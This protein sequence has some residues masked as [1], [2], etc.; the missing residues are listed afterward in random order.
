MIFYL[1]ALIP[2]LIG[3]I[4]WVRSL[5]IVLW[6]WLASTAIGFALAGAFHYAAIKGMTD[7][8]ETWSGKVTDARQFSAWKEYYEYAVYRTESETYTDSDG[9]THTTYHQVFD[10]WEPTSRWHDAYWKAYSDIDYDLSI[11][12]SKYAYLTNK[13]G[14]QD[15]VKGDRTTWEHNSRM[16]EGDPYDYTTHWRKSRWVEPISITKRWENKVKACPSVFSF[17]NVDT[18]IPVFN[19]PKSSFPFVSSRV[20]GSAQKYMPTLLWDQLN[21]DLGPIRKINLILVG[22]NSNESMLGQYQQAKWVGGKKNDLVICAGG[23]NLRKPSWCFVFGW[24]DSNIVKQN[25]SSYVMANGVSTNMI[26]FL[27]EEITRNYK[28][29]NWSDFDYL[30]V[31]PAPRYYYSFF[32]VLFIVQVGFYIFNFKN[33]VGKETSRSSWYP[34]PWYRRF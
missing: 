1:L 9:N 3:G 2:M 15:R 13:Y 10:H 32:I 27:R 16:I 25:I 12:L 29:K 8:I 17:I 24:S 18:N 4:L 11:D 34:T 21:A 22:F 26:D 31:K 5:R 28:K 23:N 19:W 14:L 30:R 6:E 20:M 7:D 33:E